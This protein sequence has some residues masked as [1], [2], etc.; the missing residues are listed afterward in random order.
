MSAETTPPDL[1][2]YGAG[3]HGRVVSAIA[4][5]I[6][7]GAVV[8]G[9]AGRAIGS[10]VDG[11]RVAFAKITDVIDHHVIVTLGNPVVRK[12]LQ[13]EAERLGLTCASLVACPQS[14]FGASPGAGTMVLTAAVVNPGVVLGR[15]VIVNTAA[16]VEHDVVIGDFCHVAPRAVLLGNCQLG[17][18]VWL[19]ANATVVQGVSICAH[20]TIG[21]GAV[22]T[23]DITE[24]G[25]Y[26]G[27][28][29]RKVNDVSVLTQAP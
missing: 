25:T 14:Y 11:V 12:A 3:G 15:G 9:D 16:V 19:G 24:P 17:E 20:V 28:P 27:A 8:F 6:W 23:Q 1:C 5:R 13:S 4:R 21:A 26:V 29:A 18:E 10:E 7:P 2:L 22:V